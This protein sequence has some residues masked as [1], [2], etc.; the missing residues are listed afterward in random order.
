MRICRFNDDRLG[1]IRE[2]RIHDVTPVAKEL[3]TFSYPLPRFD[4]MIARL[5]ELLP[6][7]DRF[8]RTSPPVDVSEVKL[9]SPIANPGKVIAAPVNYQKH[10]EEAA[11]DTK[12]FPQHHVRRIHETGLFLKATSSVVG[13]GEGV[14]VRFPDRRTDH[15]IEL[16]VVIGKSCNEVAAS[17]ALDVVA[18]YLI[19]LDMTVRGPEERSLRKSVD[20]YTVLGPWF[21]TADEIGDPSGLP[22]EL[23]VNGEVR[24]SANT[25]DLVIDTP[26]LIEFASK[27]YTL[28]PGDVLLTGTPEGVA[29]VKPGDRIRA[30]IDKIGTMDVLVR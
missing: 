15:E 3:G 24:Q 4:P 7:F 23:L 14:Q 11:A 12:T 5:S 2:G 27:F 10:L 30:T 19:G 8:A 25:R 13:P 17:A 26:G 21:V 29:P 22:F 18:G 9:L 28:E 20:S 16:A 6:L 1:I